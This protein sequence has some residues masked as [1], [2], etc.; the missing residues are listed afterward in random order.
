[1]TTLCRY[2]ACAASL[3]HQQRDSHAYCSQSR[4]GAAEGDREGNTY[5][6]TRD[7]GCGVHM[8]PVSHPGERERSHG[9]TCAPAIPAARSSPE[10]S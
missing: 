8:H 4:A 7:P 5:A 3:V 2:A 10:F 6:Y 9:R 1:M